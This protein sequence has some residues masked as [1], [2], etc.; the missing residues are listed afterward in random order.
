MRIDK[1][2]FTYDNQLMDI[3]IMIQKLYDDGMSDAQIAD[4]ISTETDKVAASIINR[5][6]S[7][8]HKTT[9][10]ERGMR[11]KKLCDERKSAA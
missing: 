4:A 6:R 5:L 2:T 1:Y 7:G 10:F 11:I 3:R 9:S 8:T